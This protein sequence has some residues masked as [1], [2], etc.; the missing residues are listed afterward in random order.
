MADSEDSNTG[1]MDRDELEDA[2]DDLLE[3]NED[4]LEYHITFPSPT[5]QSNESSS[6]SSGEKTAKDFVFVSGGG[7]GAD[8]EPVVF[9]LGWAGCREDLELI[10]SL[11][12][13]GLG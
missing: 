12:C 13:S 6:S 2:R 9:L 4:D 8:T 7:F 1:R 3:D 11:R 5:L 10:W